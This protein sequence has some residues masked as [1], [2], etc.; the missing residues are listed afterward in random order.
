MLA[1]VGW[2]VA[3]L[4]AAALGAYEAYNNVRLVSTHEQ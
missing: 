1:K 2:T 3:L 4:G